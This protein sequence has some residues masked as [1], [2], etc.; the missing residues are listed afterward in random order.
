ML[1]LAGPETL[2]VR[3][4]AT[5]FGVEFGVELQISGAEAPA[6]LLSNSAKCMRLFGYPD[7]APAELIEWTAHWLKADL[8]LLNK[9]T[10]FQKRDGR[11]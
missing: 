5:A 9:P 6:A 1:N 7:V 3:Q 8:P 11:F 2:S 4:L 10:G